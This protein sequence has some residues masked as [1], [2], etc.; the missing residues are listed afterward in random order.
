MLK[1]KQVHDFG[2]K[3][4]CNLITL[5]LYILLVIYKLLCNETCVS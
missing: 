1:G 2:L 5:L 3:G 4:G